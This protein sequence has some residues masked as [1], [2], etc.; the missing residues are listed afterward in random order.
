MKSLTIGAFA[1]VLAL[2][3]ALPLEKKDVVIQTVVEHVIKTVDATTT[4][5]VTPGQASPTEA[6]VVQPSAPV[7]KQEQ[8]PGGPKEAPS[9]ATTTSTSSAPPP[10]PP[11][12]T[13]STTTSAAAYVPPPSSYVAPTS[14]TSTYVP[15]TTADA[16]P[17]PP[18]SG[19]CGDVG[20]SCSG[21]VTYYDTTDG[22]TPEV[23]KVSG[24]GACGWL[25]NGTTEDVF[26]LAHGKSI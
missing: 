26:A 12:T 18:S 25:N 9:P 10:P 20:G 4:V 1:S 22:L 24:Y 14:A 21:D 19:S 11:S 3:S 8:R 17:T 6:T 13:S 15:S 16:A 5:W 2:V 7:Q 23:F